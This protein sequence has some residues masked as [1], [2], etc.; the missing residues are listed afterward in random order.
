MPP[1][2]PSPA[3]S[4]ALSAEV[5]AAIDDL[6]LA[7][8]IVVEG[9]RTGGHRSPFHGYSTEFRQHRPYRAGDDLKHLDWKLFARS[10]RLYTRQYRETT[11]LSVMIVLD[12]SASMAFPEQGVSKFRYGSVI[13]AA[14]AYLASEQGHAV[15]LM[16]MSDDK[17]AYV[18]A[19]GGR[20]H[21]RALLARIDRLEPGGT[22]DPARTIARGEQLL[23]RRGVVMVISDF[24]DDEDATRR[25]MRHVVQRGHDVAMLQLVSRPELALPFAGQVEI[26]DLE[27]GERR[28]IDPIATAARYRSRVAAFLDRCRTGALRD[29]VDYALFMTDAPPQA[30]LR[31]YLLRRERRRAAHSAPRANTASGR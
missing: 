17:L 19:R 29:G 14:L 4:T 11:N 20:P 31:D 16:T 3:A 28:L 10:D 18:P 15:G 12:T 25:E 26:E 21:L 2:Q 1:T 13:A 7:A 30:A 27:S 23:Q 9:L 5:V 6:E 8:R 22:W 24:Y